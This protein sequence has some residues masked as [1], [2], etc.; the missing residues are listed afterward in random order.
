MKIHNNRLFWHLL[1]FCPWFFHIFLFSYSR[2]FYRNLK[3]FLRTQKVSLRIECMSSLSEPRECLSVASQSFNWFNDEVCGPLSRSPER[4]RAG[5]GGRG[6]LIRSMIAQDLCSRVCGLSDFIKTGECF[7]FATETFFHSLLQQQLKRDEPE[8]AENNK[9]L[10][11]IEVVK[12]LFQQ[13]FF[14]KW[15]L[16]FHSYFFGVANFFSFNIL[17]HHYH[18]THDWCSPLINVISWRKSTRDPRGERVNLRFT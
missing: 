5:G 18:S 7:S 14:R 11:C 4:R 6:K 13:F 12:K 2:S 15:K 16:F 17:T 8:T 3:V 1:H 9:F 10:L